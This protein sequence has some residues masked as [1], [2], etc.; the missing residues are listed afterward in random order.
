MSNEW[1][2]IAWINFDK[3]ILHGQ[4]VNDSGC[5]YPV[6]QV[7]SEAQRDQVW[8]MNAKHEAEMKRLLRSFVVSA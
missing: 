2:E 5:E 8:D 3:G 6:E 4:W 1:L 7:I